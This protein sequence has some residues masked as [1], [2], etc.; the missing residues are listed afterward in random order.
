MFA[1]AK[2]AIKQPQLLSPASSLASK[3][4][5]GTSYQFHSFI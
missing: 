1:S 4:K 3:A 5:E 2:K